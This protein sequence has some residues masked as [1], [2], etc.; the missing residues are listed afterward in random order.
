MVGQL[1]QAVD[2]CLCDEA[3]LSEVSEK[4]LDFQQFCSR[5]RQIA[6]KLS[7]SESAE[8]LCNQTWRR[9]GCAPDLIAEFE[10]A[11]E[12]SSGTNC[13]DLVSQLGAKSPG[14][15]FLE[16]LGSHAH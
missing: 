2:F 4:I 12:D 13:H 7:V 11:I 8:A 14:I 9:T 15:E 16:R 5:H 10:I 6:A 3:T 1:V